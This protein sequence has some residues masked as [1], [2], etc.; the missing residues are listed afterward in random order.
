[1]ST[2]S[3]K[4]AIASMMHAFETGDTVNVGNYFADNWVNHDP[5]LPPLTGLDGARQLIGMWSAMSNRKITI[6]DSVAEGDRVAMR[7]LIEGTHSGPF[8]GIAPTGKT[9]HVTGSGI[10][11]LVDGKATDNW[12][13]FDALGL[14][15][16]LGAIPM[17][18]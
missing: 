16:Q 14:L 6:E 9:I 5:S 18:K 3:N 11:R 7:F 17:P 2:E 4:A 8:M 15:Q 12:V 10:F 13:N 1:M